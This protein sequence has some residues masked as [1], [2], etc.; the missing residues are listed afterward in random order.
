LASIALSWAFTS[1]A[2]TGEVS[3][4]RRSASV[5]PSCQIGSVPQMAAARGFP[6]IANR[7]RQAGPDWDW[8]TLR[9]NLGGWE[10]IGLSRRRP[11]FPTSARGTLL[12]T[13]SPEHRLLNAAG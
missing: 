4:F 7:A 1:G 11:D 6:R 5:M 13:P 12:T 3:R 8:R 2:K 9:V 10:V